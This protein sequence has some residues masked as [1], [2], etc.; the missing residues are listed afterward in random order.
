MEHVQVLHRSIARAIQRFQ[1]N[2]FDFL[3]EIDLQALLFS[4]LLD[5]FEGESIVMRG[6]YHNTRAYGGTDSIRTSPAKCEYPTSRAFDVAIIDSDAVEHFDQA[7]WQERR[8]AN[9]RFWDQRVRAAVELK[10][11][12]LGEGRG[13][14]L[15][16]VERDVDKLRRY[17]EEERSRRFLGISLLFIQSAAL[18]P[19]PFY[20][21][22]EIRDDPSEGIVR[23]VVTP[24]EWRRFAA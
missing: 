6:G 5:D 14:R 13:Y 8:W 20:V 11:Y 3:Y 10:Y 2:P 9:D 24:A 23:C 19:S 4:L 21:G 22:N 18:D 7:R 1:R 15:A 17:L 16:G 12:Q